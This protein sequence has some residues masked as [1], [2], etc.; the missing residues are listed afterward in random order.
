MTRGSDWL[1]PVVLATA[2]LVLAALL[3]LKPGVYLVPAFTGYLCFLL[4][5]YVEAQVRA[6]RSTSPVA[7]LADNSGEWTEGLRRLER[8]LSGLDQP[9]PQ[10]RYGETLH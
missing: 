1:L 7:P 6:A 2:L 10:R 9:L 8:L 4:V 5:G 3:W